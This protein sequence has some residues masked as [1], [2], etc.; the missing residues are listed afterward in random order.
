[1]K[2]WPNLLLGVSV[3]CFIAGIVGGLRPGGWALGIPFG[4]VFLGL[5]VVIRMLG[6]E[7]AK[8]DDEQHHREEL[9]ERH[10]AAARDPETET[11]SAP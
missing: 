5:Y 3:I 9:A 8:F 2:H 4:A 10:E 6:K 11:K 7:A 1:M